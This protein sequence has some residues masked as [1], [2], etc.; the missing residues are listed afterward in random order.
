MKKPSNNG[1][2]DVVQI[3]KINNSNRDFRKQLRRDL[4]FLYREE[5]A[6]RNKE[7]R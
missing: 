6:R 5:K 1:T 7:C 3:E 4:G 2:Y